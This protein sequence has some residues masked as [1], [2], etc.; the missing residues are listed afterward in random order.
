M[1]TVGRKDTRSRAKKSLFSCSR[2]GPGAELQITLTI[3]GASTSKALP[4]RAACVVFHSYAQH[5]AVPQRDFCTEDEPCSPEDLPEIL[6]CERKVITSSTRS[7]HDTAAKASAIEYFGL[8]CCD[9]KKTT[10]AEVMNSAN[11]KACMSHLASHHTH[12]LLQN[13][14]KLL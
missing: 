14:Y 13:N 7:S 5:G 1:I 3:V 9:N 8:L 6:Y 12:A 11:N 2:P 10:D 4:R